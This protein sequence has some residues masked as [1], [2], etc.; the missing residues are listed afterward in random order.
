MPDDTMT[1]S[2][3]PRAKRAS[4][5]D[6][7]EQ[8]KAVD[9]AG[10]ALADF[11]TQSIKAALHRQAEMFDVLR[12]IGRDWFA[13][14]AS[15][16]ELALKLPNKLSAAHTV[17]DALSAYQEWLSEWMAMCSEDGRRLL[18]NSQR[19]MDRAQAASSA[20]GEGLRHSAQH[21]V[22]CPG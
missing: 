16:A 4:A 1:L 2:D 10:S 21:D 14:A 7:A 17:P 9:T 8:V 13:R 3:D 11:G 18:A 22:R 12:D 19:V 15:E 5:A 6:I 20:A